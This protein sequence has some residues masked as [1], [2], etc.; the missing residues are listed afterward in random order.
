MASQSSQTA[1]NLNTEEREKLKLPRNHALASDVTLMPE[2]VLPSTVT[3]T[4]RF[5]GKM[6]KEVVDD[7]ENSRS[8]RLRAKH[9]NEEESDTDI[10]EGDSSEDKD[11]LWIGWKKL[12]KGLQ[13][14]V[15]LPSGAAAPSTFLFLEGLGSL[16]APYAYIDNTIG[17]DGTKNY[18]SMKTQLP[19]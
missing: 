18:S 8:K 11:D 3:E 4:K 13:D 15:T 14:R 1:T 19:L 17:G 5:Q 7:M 12:L 10:I 2:H 16:W 6:A 9:I